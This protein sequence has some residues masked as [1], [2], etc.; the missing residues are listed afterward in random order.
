MIDQSTFYIPALEQKFWYTVLGARLGCTQ[1]P[2]TLIAPTGPRLKITSQNH[3]YQNNF[4][5]AN[6]TDHLAEFNIPMFRSC[7]TLGL[8]PMMRTI[9]PWFLV[10]EDVLVENFPAVLCDENDVFKGSRCYCETGQGWI[11]PF[12]SGQDP[13]DINPNE[14]TFDDIFTLLEQGYQPA[15]DYINKNK[16]V[17]QN[18]IEKYF[19]EQNKAWKSQSGVAGKEWDPEQIKS[20]ATDFLNI[21]LTLSQNRVD[22]KPNV[23]ASS[24]ATTNIGVFH[25]TMEAIYELMGNPET[26][27]SFLD[28]DTY[29]A[30]KRLTPD[31]LLKDY[32]DYYAPTLPQVMYNDPTA[33]T[34][35]YLNQVIAH[36][37]SDNHIPRYPEI[38]HRSILALAN[39]KISQSS[40][41]VQMMPL[42]ITSLA[43]VGI[44]ASPIIAPLLAPSVG[45]AIT[46]AGYWVSQHPII[47]S[48]IMGGLEGGALSFAD[49]MFNNT[50]IATDFNNVPSFLQIDFG[51]VASDTAQGAFSGAMDGA[52]W[53]TLTVGA[54]KVDAWMASNNAGEPFPDLSSQHSTIEI[55]SVEIASKT[56][57]DPSIDFMNKKGKSTLSKHAEKHGYTSQDTYLYDAREFLDNPNSNNLEY[58]TSD[59]GTYFQ[60]DTSTNEFGIINQYGG[61]STYF[62]PEEGLQYWLEQI[63]HYKPK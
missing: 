62:K 43:T 8:C 37:K 53:G 49:S 63:E 52:F 17:I 33:K 30:I 13:M 4:L 15:I 29:T 14:L 10:K 45:Y 54:S 25:T 24:E 21:L 47:G 5:L 6:Q 50:S 41:L 26:S 56:Y 39:G 1:C 48:A 60:Y 2:E 35:D 59:E 38:S 40:D 55:S 31:N 51:N 57:R 42:I 9:T 7:L 27:N 16:D 23:I 3:H 11:Y 19:S 44:I 12:T 58:F 20:D 34:R 46:T 32:V 18:T 36:S 22:G 28:E 61:I